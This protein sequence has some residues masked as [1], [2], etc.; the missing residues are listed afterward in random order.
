MTGHIPVLLEE[1][2]E[3]FGSSRNSSYL[4]LTFGGGGHARAL[5]ERIPDS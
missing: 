3:F 2:L 4:D 5:L 1:V